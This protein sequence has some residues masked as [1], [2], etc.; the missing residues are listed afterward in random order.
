M[1]IF[2]FDISVS[3]FGCCCYFIASKDPKRLEDNVAGMDDALQVHLQYW[4]KQS[5]ACSLGLFVPCSFYQPC[6]NKGRK[7]LWTQAVNDCT[8]KANPGVQLGGENTHP[9]L[10][11]LRKVQ[12]HHGEWSLLS[13]VHSLE[14]VS[15]RRD[16]SW[17]VRGHNL[18]GAFML[19]IQTFL[20][21]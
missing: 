6:Q 17:K 7:G 8:A 13:T 21:N 19:R 20:D 2:L 18:A 16:K 1:D 11:T 4:A 9:P 14:D 5:W 15:W 10:A 12:D 3:F